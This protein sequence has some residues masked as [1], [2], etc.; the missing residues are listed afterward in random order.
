M[1]LTKTNQR[2]I[3]VIF[4]DCETRPRKIVIKRVN[5]YPFRRCD[6]EQFVSILEKT[7][8]GNLNFN[9]RRCKNS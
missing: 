1:V 4:S 9:R 6:L 3:P 5:G 7:I 2:S 8:N